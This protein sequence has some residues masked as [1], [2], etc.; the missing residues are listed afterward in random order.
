MKLTAE[1][2]KDNILI[3]FVVCYLVWYP[4]HGQKIAVH[5]QDCV[6]EQLCIPFGKTYNTLKCLTK[7]VEKH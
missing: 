6:D 1:N 7:K 4:L 5:V 3:S 2:N